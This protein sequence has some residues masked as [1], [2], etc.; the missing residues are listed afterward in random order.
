VDTFQEPDPE[1]YGEGQF[2]FFVVTAW[3]GTPTNRQPDEHEELQWFSFDEVMQLD[4][5]HPMYYELLLRLA[6]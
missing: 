3:T 4:L 2:H 5:P 6:S 1:Q